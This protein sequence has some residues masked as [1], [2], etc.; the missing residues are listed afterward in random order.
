MSIKEIGPKLKDPQNWINVLLC[1][2]FVVALLAPHETWAQSGNVY[3]PRSVQMAS[4]V[5]RGIILQT[6]EVSV[7]PDQ[8]N[9]YGGMGVGASLGGAVGMRLAKGQSNSTRAALGLVGAILGGLG[10]QKVTDSIGGPKAIEYIVQTV[11]VGRE[12]ARVMAITQPEPGPTLSAGAPVYLV[13]TGATW[14][15]LAQYVPPRPTVTSHPEQR[16]SDDLVLQ[17]SY[18]YAALGQ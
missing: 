17:R 2:G 16:R 7:S 3:S 13:Q 18:R 8:T 6:R 15:V 4:P 5:T 12:Q 11:P 14:R 1:I 10:G 9:R